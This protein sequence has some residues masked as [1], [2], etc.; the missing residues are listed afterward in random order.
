MKIIQSLLFTIVLLSVAPVGAVT[1]SLTGNWVGLEGSWSL[2]DS[3]GHTHEGTYWGGVVELDI[4]GKQYMA[5]PTLPN[6]SPTDAMGISWEADLY[7]HDYL[8]AGGSGTVVGD[9]GFGNPAEFYARASLFFVNGLLGYDPPDP[10]WA[11]SFDEMIWQTLFYVP[12]QG[13]ENEDFFD[14]ANTIYDV[15]SGLTLRDV[16]NDTI[17]GG[18]DSNYDYSGF[19]SVLGWG[20][21][22][23]PNE[24]LV[25]M[26][27]VP[28]SPALW[29]FASGLIG[30]AAAF[31]KRKTS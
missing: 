24:F 16:Y 20:D 5:M 11:A 19:M 15:G 4:D 3:A 26:S 10:L 12:A 22:A 27:P 7:T 2:T 18:L 30:L 17:A 28:I 29:L 13:T 9:Y 8:L 14:N 1:V 23:A 6:W 21:G 25:F 31:R